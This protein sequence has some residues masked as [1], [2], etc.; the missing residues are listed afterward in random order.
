[1][2]W[3]VFY[4][5]KLKVSCQNRHPKHGNF[6]SLF[7]FFQELQENYITSIEDKNN[8]MELVTRHQRALLSRTQDLL[9]KLELENGVFKILSSDDNKIF[10]VC[11]V[12][13]EKKNRG[14]VISYLARC[15][16]CQLQ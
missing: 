13:K 14:D 16:I 6:N 15:H 1:M 4:D 2:K 7:I 12:L 9:K 8:S 5:K 11:I 10:Q 3:L